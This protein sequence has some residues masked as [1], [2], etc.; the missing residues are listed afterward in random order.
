MKSLNYYQRLLKLGLESL[1]LRRIRNDLLFTY[2]ILFGLVDVKMS[3]F[4]EMKAND[5]PTRGHRYRLTAPTTKN[6]AR[7]NFFFLQSYAC[8]ESITPRQNKL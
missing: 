4:F 8:L 7:Y 6:G 2:K 3:D 1:E 5:R